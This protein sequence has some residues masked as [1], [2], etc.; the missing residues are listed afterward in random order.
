M[1]NY[2]PTGIPEDD[3]K[4]IA[5]NIRN[6]FIALQ[7]AINSKADKLARQSTSTTSLTLALGEQILVVETDKD[8]GA[9]ENV[10]LVSD[11]APSTNNMS[12]MVTEY[13]VTTGLLTVDITSKNGT[14]SYADW[15][16]T[17]SNQSGVTLGTNS[18]TGAQNLARATVVS[19]ATT[20]DIWSAD[21]NQINWTGTAVTTVF[22]TAP[23]AGASRKLICAG[24]CSFVAGA[25]MLIAGI[26][27]GGTLICA[28]ND[29]VT[30]EAI[31]TTQF[32]LSIIR[33]AGDAGGA[34]NTSSAIDV[35]LT[36]TSGSLQN[37]SMTA[38]DKKVILPSALTLAVGS[39]LF[40]IYNAG[41]YRFTVNANG[42][43][44]LCY[45]NPGQYV[46]VSCNDNSTAAGLWNIN[47]ER[48]NRIY[49]GN[50]AE[51]INAVDSR[52]LA[53][54]MLSSTQAIA[55]YRNN[56]TT[57][58]NVVV[59]NYG[60]ASGAPVAINAEASVDI[61]IAAQTSAQA[62]VCYK[63]STGV[64]KGYVIDVSGNVPT[65]GSV[66]TIDATA[67]GTG[68][69][70]VALSSTKLLCVYQTSTGS[71]TPRE[72]VLD[73]AA[74]AIT[75][76]AEAVAD[77]TGTAR[78]SH[79][80]DKISATKAIVAFGYASSP[81]YP[82]IRLQSIT[83]ST[84]AATGSA[85]A[86]SEIGGVALRFGKWALVVLS[87]SR[88]LL[89]RPHTAD[90]NDTVL[91]L[92]DISGTSAVLLRYKFLNL[93]VVS[94]PSA[95]VQGL[96]FSAK[97]ID[98]NKAYVSW[99]GGG[100]L[101]VDAAIVTVTSDNDILVSTVSEKLEASVTA[102][103]T[104]DNALSSDVCV[105]DSTHIMQISRNVNTYLSAKTIEVSS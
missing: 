83:V 62:T 35:T 60:S 84:P 21:G 101:G 82:V 89:I 3:T 80:V 30:V 50:T 18:F 36:S 22:P 69:S 25:N 63:T 90:Y 39:G 65:A 48:V 85:L 46:M 68:T 91:T 32:H 57:Y 81:Y 4:Y 104:T 41:A 58:L 100:S 16:V 38:A 64:T 45:V 77:A 43:G 6:E 75:A 28:A 14:G 8:F 59:L 88:A 13:N 23:Q 40:L 103:S 9:G 71:G 42:N 17:I 1:S 53:V 52:Y 79:L 26:Q 34:L 86:L 74:S 99:H 96:Y 105:L 95:D 98:D 20:G 54:A 97:R 87:S 78:A 37:V 47:G 66:A 33:Y 11:A 31:S 10:M 73:I 93:G 24:A 67:G 19:H 70:I 7:T 61:S 55:A 76:S 12:G 5:L 72:R 44:F 94:T 92:L 49:G 102:I 51:V 56:S 29:V 2:T 27:S 15:I